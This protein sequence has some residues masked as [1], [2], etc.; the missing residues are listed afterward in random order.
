MKLQIAFDLTDLNKALTI[1]AD[2]HEYA[3]ILEVGSL[4]IYKYGEEAIK[5]FKENFPHKPILADVKI[6]DRGKEAATIAIQAGADWITVMAG[7]GRNVIHT[8]GN[9]AHEEG[10]KVMLDLI[11]ANSLGQAALDAKS[12]GVDAILFHKPAGEDTQLTFLDRWDMIRQNTQLPIFVSAPI[13]RENIHEIL[14]INP[15][16]IVLG[17]TIVQ[18]ENPRE[19]AAFFRE[20]MVK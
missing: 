14:S 13:T 16:G 17:K 7:T 20:L 2:V 15:S 12:L 5:K 10:K 4:L 9:T 18:A 19:E 1:A 6:V 11:D 3:D 8:A